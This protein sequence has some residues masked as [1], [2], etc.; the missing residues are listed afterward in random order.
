M[1]GAELG[2]REVAYREVW[3]K[4]IQASGYQPQ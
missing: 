1:S 2:K 4:I 3:A